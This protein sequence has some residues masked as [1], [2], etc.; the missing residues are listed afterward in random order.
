MATLHILLA[1][2]ENL[3]NLIPT[4]A[5]L[6]SDPEFK[7]NSALIL[8]SEEMRAR[9][10]ILKTALE[11]AG[12]HVS[13]HPENCPDHDLRQIRQWARARADEIS[14]NHHDARR[15]LNLTGGTKL[16]TIAFLEAFQ[17]RNTEIIYCDTE[18][19]GIEYIDDDRDNL[20][21][22]VNTLKLDTYL[23]AQGYRVQTDPVDGD[24]IKKRAALTARLVSAASRSERLIRVL[25]SAWYDYDGRNNLYARVDT[26]ELDK[27]GKDLIAEIKQLELLDTDHRFRNEAAARYLGG[28]WLEEWCWCI[29]KELEENDP[30]KRL[31]SDRWGIG[32]RIFPFDAANIPSRSYPLNELDAVYVHRNRMLLIEC[33]TGM[34]ISDTDESQTILNKLEAIGDQFGGRL[35]KKWLL[36]AR[37]VK[38]SQARERARRYGIRLIEPDELIGLKKQVMEWMTQ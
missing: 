2:G 37:P 35:N 31:K 5:R 4:I 7:A 19:S 9:A 15:I 10:R 38:S 20:K 34:Q 16:M 8:T 24:A 27:N 1:S 6:Q 18:H 22:P 25:N 29:G 23:A 14:A 26:K 32:L 3:P 28:G 21:L 30:G 33:K 17:S 12:A 36:S 13:I 11:Y